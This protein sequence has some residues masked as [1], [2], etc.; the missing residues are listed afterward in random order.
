MNKED[1]LFT[2]VVGSW[3]LSNNHENMLRVFTDLIH[4]GIDFPCYPQLLSMT[5]QFLSPLSE[6]ITQLEEIDQKFYLY[7]DFE[8]PKKPSA[9][10]YGEFI[11]NFF[12]DHP[13]LKA[14][15][16]GTKACLTGPFTLTFEI[17]LK[18]EIAEGLK[19]IIFEEPRAVM[20]D[21][22]VDK[23]ADFTKQIATAY[24]IMGIDIISCDEPILGLLVGKKILFHSEDFIINTINKAIS[25]IRKLSSIHVCGRISPYLRD[26]LLKTDVKILDHEFSTN[27]QNFKIFEKKHF[28]GTDKFLALG[29][30][31]SK[32]VRTQDKKISDYVEHV[33]FLKKFIKRG[34]EQ[35]GKENLII[36][37][38]CG[39]LPLK[40]TFG[41][42]DGYE[43][44]IRK[45]KNMVLALN[46]LK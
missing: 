45:V 46:S 20:V 8:V 38:D 23:F 14:S 15:I 6:K 11:V 19:P 17:I 4:L 9:L 13:D 27:E 33:D 25:G 42:K 24:N 18:N 12:N 37:P 29:T 5:H 28:Q 44:A 21:W 40:E 36:K 7:N 1:G 26:L 41:E 10:E 32:F 16:K 34:I 22:I 31:H 30:V 39:F 35:Y 3:P 43:I 2:T